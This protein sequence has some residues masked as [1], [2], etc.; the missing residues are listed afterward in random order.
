[1][2]LRGELQIDAINSNFE[3][4]ESAFYMKSVSMPK[5]EFILDRKHFFIALSHVRFLRSR[6]SNAHDLKKRTCD[7]AI[8]KCLRSSMIMNS[9]LYHKNLAE[10]VVVVKVAL[11]AKS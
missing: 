6:A 10:I 11:L 3:N 8:K 4:L 5:A 9:A 7:K 1:M 2:L